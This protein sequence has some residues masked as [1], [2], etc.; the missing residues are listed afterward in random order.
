M[1]ASTE[2]QH[3]RDASFARRRPARAGA[4]SQMTGMAPVSLN[5]FMQSKSRSNP[6]RRAPTTL[7]VT[8][9]VPC[10]KLRVLLSTM[11][12]TQAMSVR[13]HP[14]DPASASCALRNQAA[15]N[16][17]RRLCGRFPRQTVPMVQ[18]C[19]R[20]AVNSRRSAASQCRSPSPPPSASA[21]AL[22]RCGRPI[23]SPAAPPACGGSPRPDRTSGVRHPERGLARS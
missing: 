2:P 7:P 23:R 14:S 19:K 9:H 15:S 6:V 5:R 10:C 20:S 3:S 17:D 12:R 1:P 4:G 22:F 21:P 13:R 11:L 18:P 16:A 8:A